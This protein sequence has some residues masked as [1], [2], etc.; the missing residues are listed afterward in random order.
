M[1]HNKHKIPIDIIT[2]LFDSITKI[3]NPREKVFG[4]TGGYPKKQ[5]NW[6][7]VDKEGN[8]VIYFTAY[9]YMN[10]NIAYL[11]SSNKTEKPIEIAGIKGDLKFSDF[12]LV[13]INHNLEVGYVD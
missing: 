12:R 9:G 11:I 4:C 13:F 8:Y 7:A 5:L 3:A 6:F 2:T 10:K 1:R